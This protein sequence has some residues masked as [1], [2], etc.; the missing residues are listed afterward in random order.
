MESKLTLL[1]E[2]PGL[3]RKLDALAKAIQTQ[4]HHCRSLTGNT[5]PAASQPQPTPH[6][7]NRYFQA[8]GGSSFNRGD[9]SGSDEGKDLAAVTDDNDVDFSDEVLVLSEEQG[10]M[11]NPRSDKLTFWNLAVVLPFLLYL[12]VMLPFRLCLD[13]PAPRFSAVYWFEFLIDLAFMLDIALNFCTGIVVVEK[14][15]E[16]EPLVEYD[17]RRVAAAYLRSWL[18]IDVL[19]GVPFEAIEL[20]SGGREA[21]DA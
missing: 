8:N 14:G 5:N 9:D 10:W 2:I 11:M 20:A 13:F 3:H 12:S 1:D 21:T 4:Q 16:S 7:A 19:S 15:Q 17:L 18:F 6:R